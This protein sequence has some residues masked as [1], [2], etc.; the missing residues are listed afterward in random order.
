MLHCILMVYVFVSE[1]RG[2][3]N[4]LGAYFFFF[5]V[6]KIYIYCRYLNVSTTGAYYLD[7][8]S[9][10]WSGRV[11]IVRAAQTTVFARRRN[12]VGANINRKIAPVL[13]VP[14]HLLR[15]ISR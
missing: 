11:E 14:K 10:Y 2:K 4:L 15:L 3:R 8:T 6:R 7:N 13:G 9:E 1:Y 12:S 5:F